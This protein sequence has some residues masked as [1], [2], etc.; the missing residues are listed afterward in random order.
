MV[1]VLTAYFG[2]DQFDFTMSSAAPNLI[3]PVRQY[4]S[5]S[6]ALQDILDAQ[7]Y[8]GMH[9]RNST[10]GGATLGESVGWHVAHNLFL[11]RR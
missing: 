10:R 11:P 1:E 7:I 2:T 8:G 5:F 6:A 9:Y 4:H 3:Q